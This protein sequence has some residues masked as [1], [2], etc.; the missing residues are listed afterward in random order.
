MSHYPLW[1][2][3]AFNGAVLAILALDLGVFQKKEHAIGFREAVRWSVLWIALSLMFNAVILLNPGGHFAAAG[4]E[5]KTAL[6]F[7]TGY[8]IELALSV[9]NLFVFLMLF[10]Y[11]R[12]P[13]VLQHRVLFFGILGALILRATL[14]FAGIALIKQYHW[15]MY[16]FGAFLLLTG[17]KMLRAGDE[18]V[19]P[20]H[21]P[22]LKLLRRLVPITKDYLGKKFFTREAGRLFAT[23][24][25]VVL[26]LVE[27]TDLVFALD[28]IPAVIG[29]TQ[30][31]FI[32]YTSNICAILGLRSLYFALAGF[33]NMFHHLGKGLA[34]IL[35]FVAAKMLAADFVHVPIGAS[36]GVVAGILAISVAASIL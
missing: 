3:V 1:L 8:L 33:M 26:V 13:A 4:S 6:E 2:W 10:T 9:D 16:V 15:M 30:N 19:H 20:E 24:L 32:V 23:P 35:I 34:I 25:F 31:E 17:V 14:I 36:L 7:L 28:S 21:N 22:I 11:F 29:I 5:Q 27:T 18:E 12:V